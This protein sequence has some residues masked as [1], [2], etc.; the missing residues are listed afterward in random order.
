[1]KSIRVKSFRILRT[2]LGRIAA[3]VRKLPVILVA[4]NLPV[5][6]LPV[7]AKLLYTLTWNH[8]LSY[9]LKAKFDYAI[10]SQTGSKQV[11]C[12]SQTE[13]KFGL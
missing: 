13:L 8:G 9:V 2:I 12:W 6:K 3:N 1:M 7:K 11:R 10:W 5:C 4:D